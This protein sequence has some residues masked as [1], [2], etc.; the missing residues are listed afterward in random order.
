MLQK[1]VYPLMASPAENVTACCSAMPTSNVRSGMASIIMLRLH[2]V[3]M[4]GVM[5]RI[6]LFFLASSSMVCPKTSWNLA[7]IGCVV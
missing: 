6:L 3:G 4:A 5:P 1:G 2:P 7:G